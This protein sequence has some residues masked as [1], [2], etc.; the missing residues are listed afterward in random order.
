MRDSKQMTPA[1]RQAACVRI[2]EVA[3]GYA[4]GFAEAAEID[5]LGILPATRLA[6]WRAL[7][8]LEVAPEHLLLDYLFLPEVDMPQTALIKGDCRSLSIAAASVLAKTAR[9]ARLVE[10]EQEYPG[11]G[12]AR[13]KGYGTAA[14]RAA[15]Q[16]L[17]PCPEH[18]GRFISKPS[19]GLK[20]I[21]L[22]N[23]GGS[24]VHQ[25][26]HPPARSVGQPDPTRSAWAAALPSAMCSGTKAGHWCGAKGAQTAACWWCSPPTGRRRVT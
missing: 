17:G 1:Q 4:V 24:Y 18:G 26:N 10:L 14:H 25:E 23:Q 12:F 7:Q 5:E 9:D 21:R 16:R 15:L 20:P 8:A 2:Q 11:Y 6:A 22:I 3:L 19:P 13:H